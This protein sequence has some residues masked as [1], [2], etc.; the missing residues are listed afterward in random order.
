MM[1]KWIALL[2]FWNIWLTF[3]VSIMFTRQLALRDI[4]RDI[5][6]PGIEP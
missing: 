2:V 3:V 6:R 4:L 5:V 1:N